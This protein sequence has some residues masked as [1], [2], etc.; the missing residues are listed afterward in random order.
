MEAAFRA[1]PSVV[2]LELDRMSSLMFKL[3]GYR[4]LLPK[5]ESLACLIR[6]DSQELFDMLKMPR[7][8]ENQSDSPLWTDIII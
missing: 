4:E 6:D 5:L 7:E 1:G 8:C 2:E 3:L